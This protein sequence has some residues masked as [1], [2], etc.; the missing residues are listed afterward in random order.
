MGDEL[1]SAVK[2]RKILTGVVFKRRQYYFTHLPYL[3]RKP[4]YN[5]VFSGDTAMTARLNEEAAQYPQSL[6]QRSGSMD[7]VLYQLQYECMCMAIELCLIAI[8]SGVPDVVAYDVRDE[9]IVEMEQERTTRGIVGVFC[10]MSMEFATLARLSRL[11]DASSPAT[12]AMMAYISQHLE[13]DV[14]LQNIAEAGGLSKNYACTKFK[15]ETGLNVREF[16]IRERIGKAKQLLMDGKL[17]SYEISQRLH[18]CS[19]SY[20]NQQFRKLTSMTPSEYRK[21]VGAM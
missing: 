15:R 10:D 20:F 12:A 9:F 14:S 4:Y 11:K 1:A 6:W 3:K 19:Q 18:F 7:S 13:E 16:M 17:T 21:M 8:Q 5:A 2:R